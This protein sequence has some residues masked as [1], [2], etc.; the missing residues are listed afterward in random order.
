MLHPLLLCFP[1]FCSLSNIC[2]FSI[3]CL[4]VGFVSLAV[5]SGVDGYKRKGD[6]IYLN[7]QIKLKSV[8]PP[9]PYE[10][11]RSLTRVI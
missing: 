4:V 5:I 2:L 8:F 6:S 10:L 11:G 3:Q 9:R 1:R 7:C